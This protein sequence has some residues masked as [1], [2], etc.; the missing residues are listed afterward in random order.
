MRIQIGGHLPT[1]RLVIDV[2]EGIGGLAAASHHVISPSFM[3][4]QI[5]WFGNSELTLQELLLPTLNHFLVRIIPVKQF[6]DPPDNP[7]RDHLRVGSQI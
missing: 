4:A 2:G 1:Y 6:E 7:T 3:R 5:R